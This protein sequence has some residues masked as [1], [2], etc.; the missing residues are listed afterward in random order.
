MSFMCDVHVSRMIGN[1]YVILYCC[2]RTTIFLFSFFWPFQCVL[3]E[4]SIG[5][6]LSAS[7]WRVF[8][9]LVLVWSSSLW[10]GCPFGVCINNCSLMVFIV[11]FYQFFS[12]IIIAFWKVF[13]WMYINTSNI[14]WPFCIRSVPRASYAHE[15][16]SLLIKVIANLHCFVPDVCQGKWLST[17]WFNQVWCCILL[18]L[19]NSNICFNLRREGSVSQQ[20][21][22]VHTEGVSET[23]RWVFLYFRSRQNFRS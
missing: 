9:W 3:V 17:S 18:L 19:T 10:R 8:I 6:H 12:V 5:S 15:R 23:I 11:L 4:R 16:T 20:V 14:D 1:W 22:S 7:S 2:C 13:L 21:H